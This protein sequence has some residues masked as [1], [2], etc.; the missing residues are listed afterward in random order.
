MTF[1]ILI[2]RASVAIIFLF[3]V[4][5]TVAAQSGQAIYTDSLQNGWQN[6]GWAT[7]NY[8]NTSPVHS[9]SDSISVTATAWEGLQL[10]HPDQSSTPY[11][12]ISFWL[13]GGPSGGQHLQV[14]GLVDANGSA[15]SAESQRYYLNPLPTNSWQLF[16]V[17]LSALGVANVA[18]FTGFVIQDSTG[19]A[20]PTFYVDDITLNSNLATVTL[21]SPP[22]NSGYSAPASIPLAATV[23]TNGQTINSV[24]FLDGTTVLKQ[25]TNPPYAYLWTNVGVGDYSLSANVLFDSTNSASSGSADVSVTGVVPVPITVDAHLNQLPISPLIYGTA[26]ATSNNLSDLNFTLNR[27]GGN[28]ETDYNWQTNAQNLDADWYFESTDSGSPLPGNSADQFVAASKNGGA[29]P[30]I[31]IPMIGWVAKLGPGRA[32]L[33]SYSTNKYG[34]QTGSDPYW[35]DAG[36]GVSAATN[37]RITNNDPN[38]AYVPSTPA[39]QLGYVQH[40]I[41]NLGKSTNGGVRYYIMDNEHSIWFGTHQDIHPVGPTMREIFQD[42]TNYAS[43][44][45]GADSNVLVLGPEEW[46]WGGYFNSGYDQ[47]WSGAN[48]NYNQAQYPDRGSNGG[49]DYMP[50]LLNQL[51]Q[52]NTNSGVRLL[53]YFTLHCYPQENNVSGDAV[54]DATEL[55]RNESTRQFWDTNYVDPS[56]INSVIMLIPRMKGWVAQYYP[57]TKIGITEYNWGAE[58]YM[59]GATAQADILGIFGRE[60]LDLATRWT[61]PDPST[62]TYLAMKMYRNY[63]GNKSTFGDTSVSATGPN[64]DNVSTFAAVRSTD[65]ALTV[66][67]I[68]KQSGY[69]GAVSMSISNFVLNG[70]AQVWQLTAANAITRLGDV[71]LAGNVLTSTVPA[72]SITLFVVAAG[73]SGP[74][75]FSVSAMTGTSQLNFSL[76]GTVGQTCILQFSTNLS[77]WL[78]ISTNTLTTTQTN[79][80]ISA[81]GIARAFYRVKVSP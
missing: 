79:V 64:P 62:P 26:F 35:S 17:P 57:G 73:V 10:Y 40:L 7:L 30:L 78:P 81:S 5:M 69:S 80:V 21:T 60:G 55:L 33:D 15:N 38:D 49:W 25:V 44:V 1:R 71:T 34:A 16:T 74:P 14:Y 77:T 59:N 76:Q 56:W 6:W 72:Q 36:N 27:S 42:I 53:D 37:L 22:N 24:Q 46:G 9:G 47:Q 75:R 48:N 50:W 52:Y 4:V 29:Q 11:A 8:A 66:M 3:A 12:S 2:C 31:T 68:N 39:F 43:M 32:H 58:P 41:S 20:Q 54:D 28:N 19:S 23:V 65:G 18:N 13:N 51:H 45:K 70:T 61:V 67:V 63:D